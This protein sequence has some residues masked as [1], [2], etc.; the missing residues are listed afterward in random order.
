MSNET[1]NVSALSVTTTL[2]GNTFFVV[3]RTTAGVSN[4]FKVSYQTLANSILSVSG[5]FA[6]AAVAA[7][8]GVLTGGLFFDSNGNVKIV[9]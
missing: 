2:N 5:P 8:N 9:I 6:N 3:S 4:T 7:N 1:K